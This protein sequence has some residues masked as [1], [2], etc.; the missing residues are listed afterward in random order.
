MAYEAH[1][2]HNLLGSNSATSLAVPNYSWVKIMLFRLQYCYL[3]KADGRRMNIHIQIHNIG[4]V[5]A[6]RKPESLWKEHEGIR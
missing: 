3:M 5:K 4:V 1:D 2:V 6:S